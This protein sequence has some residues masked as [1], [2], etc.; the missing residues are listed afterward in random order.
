MSFTDTFF[1]NYGGDTNNTSGVN[2]INKVYLGTETKTVQGRGEKLKTTRDKTE[3]IAQAKARYLSDPKLQASW[4]ALLRK[5]GFE[6]DPL[7]AR[8]MWEISVSGASDWYSTSNGQQK[9]T[10]EQYLTWYSRKTQKPK[11][12]TL[13]TRQIYQ[14]AEEQIASDINTVAQ[15]ILGRTISD[16]DKTEDWYKDLVNGINKMYSKGTVTTVKEVVNPATGKKEKQVIQTP[17]FTKEGI[18]QQIEKTVRT[19]A[20]VDVER[21]DRVD[22]TKWLFGQMGGRE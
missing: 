1:N 13:P 8:A 9:V 12:P 2:F 5:N 14:V 22:F 17:G 21:K 7:N 20:P 11:T 3:T 4:T 19:A 18:S 15:N 6:T 10:P 16:T